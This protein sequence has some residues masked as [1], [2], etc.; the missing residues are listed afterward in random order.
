MNMKI[1]LDRC[2]CINREKYNCPVVTLSRSGERA[3]SHKDQF[4]ITNK[5]L[6]NHNY[7]KFVINMKILLVLVYK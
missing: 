3:V 7:I 2:L 6:V 5:V 1:L 4:G